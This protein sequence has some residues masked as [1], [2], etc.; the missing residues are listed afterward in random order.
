MRNNKKQKHRHLVLR[1]LAALLC[2]SSF[3][4]ARAA[5]TDGTLYC[6]LV[7]DEA[8][9]IGVKNE[10]LT[11]VNIPETV[12]YEGKQYTVTTIGEYAFEDMVSLS[13]VNI[14]NSVITIQQC[15]FQ[16]TGLSSITIPMS[17]STIERGA[18]L[19]CGN[20]NTLYYNAI[21]CVIEG[22]DAIFGNPWEGT[23]SLET[24][25]IGEE[26]KIIPDFLF[27]GCSALT[28]INIPNS[29]KTIGSY[30]FQ[31]CTGLNSVD[32][33]DSVNTIGLYAFENCKGLTSVSI[34][35]SVSSLGL[36]AFHGCSGIKEVYFNATK[37]ATET[38]GN[39]FS[40]YGIFPSSIEKIV[41]G[42][43]VTEIPSYFLG[44]CK[45]LTSITIPESVAVIGQRAFYQCVGIQ[46]IIIPGSIVSIG[47][48]AFPESGLKEVYFDAENCNQCSFPSSVEK[49][50]IGDNVKSI[51]ANAFRGLQISDITIPSAV[52]AIGE[53]AFS[54]CENLK[55]VYYNAE[56]CTVFGRYDEDW[57]VFLVFPKTIENVIF[58]DNVRNIPQYAFVA[59]EV[60]SISL[61][62]SVRTI[63]AYAF[64]GCEKLTEV[65]TPSI[66]DWLNIS[67]EDASANPTS[68]TKK[69]TCDGS[70][71]RRLVVPEGVNRIN[72]HAF[73]NCE[74]IVTVSLPSGI[75]SV[76]EYAF[77][78]CAA[79]QRFNFQALEDF[80][81]VNY[82]TENA[83]FPT[84]NDGKIYINSEAFDTSNIGELEWPSSLKH[85]PAYAFYGYGITGITVPA[86]L[87]SIGEA[88]FANSSLAHFKYMGQKDADSMLPDN[89]TELPGFTFKNSEL[90]DI[91]LNN[92]A[93]IGQEAFSN[94]GNI[95]EIVFPQSLTA[96][97][98]YAFRSCWNLK[99]VEFRGTPISSGNGTFESCYDISVVKMTDPNAWSQ[100]DFNSENLTSNPLYFLSY[101]HYDDESDEQVETSL[102]VNGTVVTNLVLEIPEANVRYGTFAG[103]KIEKARITSKEIENA[104]FVRSDLKA[105]CIDTETIGSNAF[106]ECSQITEIYSMTE[107]PPLAPDDAFSNYDGVKLYVPVGSRAKYENADTCW[108]RFLDVVETDFAGIDEMFKANYS[109]INVGIEDISTDRVIENGPME[110]FDLNGIHVGSSLDGLA[111]GLY[112][113]RQG[114]NVNKLVIR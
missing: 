54:G 42:D 85:I 24:A 15:A 98:D 58:G 22:E 66:K 64:N 9:I 88:A 5:L 41:I 8:I 10:N 67:F 44:K 52:S 87:E 73:V 105:L 25:I 112:I 93:T 65:I 71:V 19:F 59:C 110:V 38:P 33:P 92:V 108:Y 46:S 94:C 35:S 68:I 74:S 56:N 80:L 106:G 109:D 90:T 95:E 101:D 79:L 102:Q 34:P 6:E 2:L 4:S 7:G 16:N 45:N 39:Y 86:D 104:A 18:F 1:L 49:V 77:D 20:L 53:N 30:A 100:I 113:V 78:G 99:T 114:G 29:V 97:G 12:N 57:G 17:V 31:N 107:E 111:P 26:V 63:G 43:N 14:P 13:S 84:G 28:S 11:T 103:A 62:S 37:C 89:I 21:E 70:E 81:G 75:E 48:E 50:I 76:G 32:I 3:A 60:S 51:P 47:Y 69:L 82:D 36:D 91:N 83:K 40:Y 72:A 55:T 23:S 96:L 61:P 27:S